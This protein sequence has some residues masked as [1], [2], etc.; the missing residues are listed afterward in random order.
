MADPRVPTGGSVRR[1]RVEHIM[2]T[3]IGID[4]RDP[5]VAG[6]I[7]DE[8]F[9]YLRGVDERFSSYRPESQ[10][11]RL[12]RGEL[13]VGDCSPDVRQV[14][15]LCEELRVA[16]GGSFD[17][18]AMQPD[19]HLDPTGVVKGWAVEQAGWMLAAAGARNFTIN[20]GGDVV[21]R[22]SP[23]AGRS[24]RIGIRHPVWRDRVAAVLEVGDGAIATSG[25]YERGTHIGAPSTGRSAGNFLSLTVVGP[26]L[27]YADAYATA[28]FAM[29]GGGPAWVASQPGYGG[30]AVT[31]DRRTVWTP[32]AWDL[33][34]APTS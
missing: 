31:T 22:G 3:A 9:T 32:V 30:F 2:G 21:A 1:V 34:A 25:T 4:L 33:R 15:A 16:T 14:L 29:G 5:F 11:N 13:E 7:F 6:S 10:I 24:W 26:S 19:G 20:A 23:Q 17:A 27:T 28:A 18:R 12:G 8:V